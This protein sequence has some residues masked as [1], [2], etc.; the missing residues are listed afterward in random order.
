MINDSSQTILP[1]TPQHA[2]LTL[3]ELLG[4]VAVAYLRDR[5]GGDDVSGDI[6][7]T[8]RFIIDCLAPKQTAAIAQ[9]IL[10]DQQLSQQFD[11]KL[12]RHFLAGFGLPPEIL[13]VER[14]T[15]YRNAACAKPA[16]LLANT[17]DDEEQSLREVTSIGAPELLARA[18]LW[19][20]IVS[21]DLAIIDESR[22]W[23][24]QALKGLNAQHFVNLDRFAMYVLRTM[25]LI[26]DEGLPVYDALD[27][28]LP[29]LRLPK[30][31]GQFRGIAPTT[32]GQLTKW[33]TLYATVQSK[34][35]CFLRKQTPSGVML[36]EDELRTSFERVKNDIPEIYHQV[37]SDFITA[38]GGWTVESAR[39]A[40]CN[41]ED[42][43]PLFDGLRGE[44]FNLGRATLDF[45]QER[46]PDLLTVGEKDYIERLSKRRTTEADLE[47]DRLFY[48]AH[49]DELREDRK[50]KSA[51]D[52]FVFGT[53]KENF[54]FLS[55]LVTCLESFSW[56]TLC[57]TRKL[58][59]TCESRFKKDL[60]ELNVDA[61][62]YFA[63]RYTGLKDLVGRQVTWDVGD[64]LNFP[65]LI[66]EWKVKGKQLNHSEAKAALQLKFFVTLEFETLN[67]AT[68]QPPPR[69]IHLAI[70]P[71]M[72][73]K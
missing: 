12:P 27:S 39:L 25:T 19:V 59:I 41:W 10:A 30:N 23:W 44:K 28:A 57:V 51:W 13:T 50:L 47:D 42:I 1:G 9:A 43:K 33:R 7:G 63:R 70:Q 6:N 34:Y 14:A 3:E 62:L 18:D 56:E 65:D 58:T 49:R 54:D 2:L 32:R 68:E 64:L 72:G 69:P 20:S 36:S 29:A 22:K 37:I 48:D 8:A 52:R 31:S 55:G 16:L 15:Y 66:E 45:Y 4:N 40:D 21:K 73:G 26:K 71:S 38:P 53:P 35:S 67:G 17:G 24:E 60:R 46:D 61:G 11:I 5:L